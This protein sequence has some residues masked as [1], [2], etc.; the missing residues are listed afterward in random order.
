M[1]AFIY[2]G[3]VL[4]YLVA[5]DEDCRLL[6]VGSWYAMTGYGLAFSRNSKYLQMF[7][8]RLLDYRDNGTFFILSL[9]F[10]N[11]LNNRLT[12]KRLFLRCPKY[13]AFFSF[14]YL[15]LRNAIP[16]IL[17]DLERLRRYWMTGTCKPG[18]EVQK[19]SDPL[20]LEQFLSA[21][22]LL[23]MGILLAAV[24]LLLEHL[25][26]KYIRQHLAKSDDGGRCAIFS[27]VSIT[28]FNIAR[29]SL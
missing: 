13:I 8:K 18:K 24:F 6:T 17:G 1:D 25:Y 14:T 5:Q 19:S 10:F 15:L 2:D 21:F 16:S 4:D 7:N 20:A 26:F 22:L 9:I 3:T 27:L 11:L 29:M 12:P 23:M 28:G